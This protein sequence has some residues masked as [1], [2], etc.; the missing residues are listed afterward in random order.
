MEAKLAQ[1]MGQM[2]ISTEDLS[3]RTGINAARITEIAAG[4]DANLNE[5]RSLSS[6]L[7][8]SLD[9]LMPPDKGSES[10]R[11]LFRSA[12]LQH[13]RTD[14]VALDRISRKMDYSLALVEG[15][16][17]ASLGWLN[18]FANSGSTYL[19]AEKNA[20]TFRRLF[21][22]DDQ[23]SP[24]FRLPQVAA[25]RMNVLLFTVKARA[26]DGASALIAG[27]PF[28]FVAERFPSRMLFTL[29]HEIAHLL[30]HHGNSGDFACVDKTTSDDSEFRASRRIEEQFAHAFAS[31]LLMPAAG[32]GI[33]LKKIREVH[34]IKGRSLGDV[35]VLFLSRIYGVS[36]AAAA[37]RCEDLRLLPRGGARSLDEHLKKEFGSAEKRAAALNLPEGPPI[38]F[39]PIPERLLAAAIEKIRSGE[40]SVG[41]ASA[42]LGLSV[43]ELFAVNAPAAN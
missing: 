31:C 22:E 24:L 4:A 5:L 27:V 35:E 7:G 19:D 2:K 10:G 28:V 21:F 23:V 11:L 15:R 29:A 14:P 13:E 30:S 1:V 40:I 18:E 33:A 39:P 12:A 36:F 37:K 8:L 17:H 41:R 38:D 20:A 43:S 32:V 34:Q 25:H 42:L 16:G 3:G 6:A 9:D 26:F